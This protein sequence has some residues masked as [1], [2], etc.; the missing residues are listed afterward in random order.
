MAWTEKHGDGWHGVYRAP[1][2]TRPKTNSHSREKDAL[3]EARDEEA[4]IRNGT[5]F[6]PTAGAITFATYFEKQWYPNRGGE[7]NTRRN[8]RSQYEAPDYGL[9]VTWGEVELRHVTNSSV[10]GWVAR[11]I[12]A[13]MSAATIEARFVTFQTVLA[14]KKGASAM[15]DRLIQYNPCQGTQ[16]P[17]RPKKKVRI[18]EP[19]EVDAI[20]DELGIWWLPMVMFE[21]DT[22]LRW[23]ELMGVRVGDFTLN[24]RSVR[25]E[26]VILELTLKDTKNGTPFLVKDYPK[27]G[28]TDEPKFIALSE[29]AQLIV[30]DVIATR[31]LGPDDFLFSAPNKTGAALGVV[32][33]GPQRGKPL[34]Q[35]KWT[36]LRTD[37]WPDGYPVSRN[38]F[39]E[40][41][42]KPAIERAG[43]PVLRFHALRASHISWLLAGGADLVSVM[44]RVGHTQFSTTKRYAGVMSDADT[45]TLDAL[46]ATRS[47]YKSRATS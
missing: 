32:G 42:W 5:W 40:Q 44:D 9:K 33:K 4:K 2:G 26:R 21:S 18:Y 36:S 13:G 22:G 11:M 30:S 41:V 24:Y 3:N 38:T 16:L 45:R 10:Q 19:D 20:A 35:E 46:S 47:R 23:G 29:D 43:L 25:I 39:R 7:L 15:R 14:A 8:Y 28:P 31:G 6:S 37:V 27:E 17:V 1:D 12:A 34:P